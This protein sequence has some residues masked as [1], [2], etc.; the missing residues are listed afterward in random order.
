MEGGLEME[1]EQTA[2]A[3]LERV[4]ASDG[5]GAAA[6]FAED[7]VI[8]DAAGGHHVGTASIT[9]F[10]SSLNSALEVLEP[11]QSLEQGE[12]LAMYGHVRTI[13][14]T[15]PTLMRWI[16]HFSSDRI[17][18]LGNSYIRGLPDLG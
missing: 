8:D 9:E 4:Q 6:L 1:R 18:H 16:F 17:A 15:E 2:R 10:I 3:Y 14:M 12:R 11:L 7:G 13:R 5:T